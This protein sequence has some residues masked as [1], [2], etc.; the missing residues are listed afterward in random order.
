MTKRDISVAGYYSVSQRKALQLNL[1]P[2]PQTYCELKQGKCVVTAHSRVV[3]S[4]CIRPVSWAVRKTA[5]SCKQDKDVIAKKSCSGEVVQNL[6]TFLSLRVT[7]LIG[8]TLY[9]RIVSNL[10]PI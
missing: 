9:A 10:K 8:R 2:L 7:E 1:Q 3:N 5:G 6:A 4:S